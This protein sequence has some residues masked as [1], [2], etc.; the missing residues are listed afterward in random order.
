MTV[1][2]IWI[3]QLV[4]DENIDNTRILSS[5]QITNWCKEYNDTFR[6]DISEESFKRFLRKA[7]W[8]NYSE[9][10]PQEITQIE[11]V[12]N[13]VGNVLAIGDLHEPFTRKGYLEFC[14]EMYIKHNC[15]TVVFIGDIA[16]NHYSSFHDS[17]P[18]SDYSAGQELTKLKEEIQKWYEAFPYALICEGNHDLIPQRKMFS[19]GLSKQWIKPMSEVLDTPNWQFSQEFILDNVYYNHGTGR[20]ARGRMKQDLISLVQGHYHSESYIEYL[21]G[22]TYRIFACQIGCGIADKS[23]AFAYGKNFAKSHINVG[24]IKDNGTLPI[25]EYMDLKK[26][27]T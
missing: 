16:D 13:N 15:K 20:K 24:I 14:K 4:L 21:V 8:N 11:T 26:D 19:A 10:E 18:D 22:R 12:R 23:F 2:Q 27:Y 9:K 17:D 6:S 3:N 7:R 1:K 5:S 25:I